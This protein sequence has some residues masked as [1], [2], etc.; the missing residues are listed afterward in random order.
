MIR[1]EKL[2]KRKKQYRTLIKKK[3]RS[4]KYKIPKNMIST[5]NKI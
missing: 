2:R 1:E 4:L 3:K 5:N